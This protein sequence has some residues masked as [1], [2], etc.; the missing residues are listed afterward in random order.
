[1]SKRKKIDA[2]DID[3]LVLSIVRR[4][5][6]DTVQELILLVQK[7]LPISEE[8]VYKVLNKL[9]DQKRLNYLEPL[10]PITFRD[11]VLSS[12]SIW[13]WLVIAFSVVS[14]VTI[15]FFTEDTYPL[16]YLRNAFGV[17]FVIFIPGYALV[18][19]LYPITVPLPTRSIAIDSIERIAL[20]LGMSLAI[21][22][23]LGLGLY[24]T[25]LGLNFLPTTFGILI[26]TLV[27]GTLGISR[28]Y[29]ARK[30]LRKYRKTMAY[31]ES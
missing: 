11:Y 8:E 31:F 6:P 22:P 27:S 18:K 20:S 19:A 24:Y 21:V 10:F 3:D 25:P 9:E 14:V 1:M 30:A 23:L 15:F 2:A 7:E 28:E 12:R 13:Y 26:L 29:S 17:I 4:R 16:T 5:H